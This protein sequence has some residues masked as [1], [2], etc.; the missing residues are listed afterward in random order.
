MILTLRHCNLRFMD[1]CFTSLNPLKLYVKRVCMC[2]CFPVERFH[3]FL[4]ILKNG[5]WPTLPPPPTHWQ[6]KRKKITVLKVI[7]QRGTRTERW[8]IG[9]IKALQYREEWW[10]FKHYSRV[11]GLLWAN[12]QTTGS[13]GCALKKKPKKTWNSPDGAIFKYMI[14][15]VEVDENLLLPIG[16]INN[17]STEPS[18]VWGYLSLS[19]IFLGE[20]QEQIC[21]LVMEGLCSKVCQFWKE[22]I[23]GD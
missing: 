23:E 5:L 6:M 8:A 18:E 22:T 1:V 15:R 21:W 4:Q 12:L 7:C 19:H 14:N 9:S 16:I 11:P 10:L 2:I 3:S 13:Q 17:Y 20:A